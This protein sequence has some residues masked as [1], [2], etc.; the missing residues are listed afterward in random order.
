VKPSRKDGGPF[1]FM[2]HSLAW[3][4]VGLA[5]VP[6]KQDTNVLEPEVPQATKSLRLESANAEVYFSLPTD[7]VHAC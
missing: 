2:D 5:F 6:F 7:E 3:D 4:D 1:E